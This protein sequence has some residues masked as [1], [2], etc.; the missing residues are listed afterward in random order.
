VE[1]GRHRAG[2]NVAE[3]NFDFRAGSRQSQGQPETEKKFSHS[4]QR[5]KKHWDD[6]ESLVRVFKIKCPEKKPRETG[7]SFW[8]ALAER[9]GDSAFGGSQSG[10]A[11]R[12]PPHCYE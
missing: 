7:G 8:T 11:L 10:V 3:I 9:S 5:N 2:R 1:I 4:A 12:L 6:K